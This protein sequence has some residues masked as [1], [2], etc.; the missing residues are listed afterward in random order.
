MRSIALCI[1]LI[2]SVA[3]TIAQEK[4]EVDQFW[5]SLQSLC[6][7]SYKGQLVLPENDPQFAGKE[8]IMHI[9]S[10]SDREIKIP[11]FVGEDR[12]RTWV[13]TKEND[14]IT[15]KHDHRHEDG[16]EDKITMYGG[17]TTNIG[18][19]TLQ[20]FPADSQTQTMI[21]AASGNVWWVT[22]DKNT[23]T[24]NLRRLGTE[25]IFTVSFDLSTPV[26]NPEAPWG[27]KE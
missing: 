7:T 4:S 5:A 6:N 16:S 15:L 19:P 1:F 8:L 17:T 27:W 25:R 26:E 10:C 11:F 12:S 23:F 3:I 13:F 14:R 22:I 18:Q 21:P 2:C 24:Y 9:R 20:V